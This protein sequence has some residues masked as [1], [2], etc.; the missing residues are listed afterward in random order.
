MEPSQV[1]F[2]KHHRWGRGSST[3]PGPPGVESGAILALAGQAAHL[4]AVRRRL[5]RVPLK[6]LR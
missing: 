3:D 4:E 1:R 2:A 6:G 5:L